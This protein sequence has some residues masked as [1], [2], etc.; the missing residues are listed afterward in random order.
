MPIQIYPVKEFATISAKEPEPIAKPETLPLI[1]EMNV[2][3]FEVPTHQFRTFGQGKARLSLNFV[4]QAQWIDGEA[5]ANRDRKK[6]Q[7]FLNKSMKAPF[8]VADFVSSRF[9][10]LGISILDRDD[11]Q[12][13]GESF[14]DWNHHEEAEQNNI[15][16]LK[17]WQDKGRK[18]KDPTLYRFILGS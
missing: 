1:M 7:E 13:F 6:L 3:D 10:V 18:L 17:V 2:E 9:T 15:N 5:E 8:F 14:P 4:E 16:I 11:I 12:R